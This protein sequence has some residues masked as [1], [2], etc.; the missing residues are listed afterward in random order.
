MSYPSDLTLE[1][2]SL[3]EDLLPKKKM[4]KPRKHSYFELFNAILYVLIT[5]CQWRMLPNDL[6]NWKTVHHYFLTWSKLETFDEILKK[7]LKNGDYNKVRINIQLYY[8]P[9]HKVQKI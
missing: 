3:F 7:S 4:T 1:Q 5:G 6:P 9:I 2:F 8:S